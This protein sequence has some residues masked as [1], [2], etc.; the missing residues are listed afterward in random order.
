MT[1]SHD[2]PQVGVGVMIFRNGKL[3]MGKR[4]GKLGHGTYGWLGDHVE[5]GETLKDCATREVLEETGLQ[6]QR[7]QFLSVNSVFIGNKHYIDIEFVATKVTGSPKVLEPD[8]VESWNWYALDK[9]PTPLFPPCI[10]ALE[11]F[12]TQCPNIV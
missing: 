10:T 8:K 9:L 12:Q 1:S 7:L 3:L 6:V 11:C 4:L 5:H 2:R